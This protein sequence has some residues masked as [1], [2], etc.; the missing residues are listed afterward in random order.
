MGR[1]VMSTAVATGRVREKLCAAFIIAGFACTRP[2]PS[3]SPAPT[4][5]AA[6]PSPASGER[7]VLFLGTSLTAGLGVDPS[8][9]YPARIAQRIRAE[10]L[11]YRVVNAGV[12]GETSA[13]AQ[14]RLDW[15]VRQRGAVAG[16]ARGAT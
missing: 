16:L 4:A 5:A 15:L 14:G 7:F 9:A 6:T 2:A 8:E 11:P 10:G 1:V 12:S 13:S 3:P